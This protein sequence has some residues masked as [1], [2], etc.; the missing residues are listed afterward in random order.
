VPQ[1][2]HHDRI[3]RVAAA[4]DGVDRGVQGFQ[5]A[6]RFDSTRSARNREVED[7]QRVGFPDGEGGF[8]GLDRRM[9]VHR[10]IRRV[11]Q[12]FSIS[13]AIFRTRASSSMI[14]TRGR[15]C[16]EGLTADSS[17]IDTVSPTGR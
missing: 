17:G 7:H 14:R 15:G 2:V 8:K 3:V 1:R 4:D 12:E 11:A 6:K 16:P 13:F 9:T 5:P 10:D